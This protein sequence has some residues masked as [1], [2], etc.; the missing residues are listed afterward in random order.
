MDFYLRIDGGVS[1][2][3]P[4][5]AAG[6]DFCQHHLPD[7]CPRHGAAYA[8]ETNYIDPILEGIADEG[9]EVI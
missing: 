3:T 9:L 8:V 4:R 2:L 6:R 7:N 1:L 5:T